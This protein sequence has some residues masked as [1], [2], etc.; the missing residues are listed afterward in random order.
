M[1]DKK[2][3]LMNKENI[4]VGLDIGSSKI[5]VFIGALENQ[6]QVRVL[7][8]GVHELKK[9]AITDLDT[10]IQSLGKAVKEAETMTGIDVK[11]VYVGV[12][13]DYITCF[14][15]K[16]GVTLDPSRNEVRDSHIA[17]VI[18]HASTLPSTAGEI[19]HIFPGDY[20]L[21]EQKGIKNP[22]GMSGVRLDAEVQIVAAK[23]LH[24][25]NVRKSVEK[26]GFEIAAMVLEPL[27]SAYAIL[28][29]EEREL[30]V[31]IIDIGAGSADL[32]V[33]FEDTVRYSVS[34]DLAG[35]IITSD[36]AKSFDTPISIARAEEMKKK[37]GIVSLSNILEDEIIG[38]PGI[39]DRGVVP[40]SRKRLAKVMHARTSEILML[41]AENL[42]KRQLDKI[43]GAGIVLTGGTSAIEG[44]VELAEEIFKK[45]VR[46]GQ[47]KQ[48]IGLGESLSKPSFSVG[49]GLLHYAAKTKQKNKRETGPQV[50]VGSLKTGIHRFIQTLKNYI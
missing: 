21:D 12:A 32:A 30:G 38:V 7:G 2:K 13:G 28:H 27:A 37:H 17:A 41:I 49:V 39:G 19:L 33:F 46:L 45:P 25:Q 5:A 11:E 42:R 6:N 20:S 15:S 22:I 23:P 31:A 8:F 50:I 48:C 1:D 14:K 9:N 10:L 36:I 16:G 18:K 26:A 47:P 40:C 44:I 24:L 43:I 4:V 35:N 29:D 34:L 3:A